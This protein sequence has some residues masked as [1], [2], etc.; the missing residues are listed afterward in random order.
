[1]EN[2]L[3]RYTANGEG[4]WAAGKRLLPPELVDEAW[5]QRKWMPKPQLPE[6]EYRFFLTA[7]GKEQ[8]EKTLLNV[9][10]KYLS[11]ITS[12]EV[13]RSSIGTVVHEDEWQVVVQKEIPQ[14]IK[15]VGFDFSWSE[16]KVWALDV[17]TEEMNIDELIW[18][19]DV[20]FLWENGGVYN[21]T[22]REVIKHPEAHQEEYDRTMNADLVHPIDIM[23]NKGRW[24]ILDGLHRLMKAS[25]LSMKTVRVRKIPRERI[26]EIMT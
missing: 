9:H 20:P 21:L 1:M 2:K 6:G 23:Q 10:K 5:E 12:E 19:F 7:K 22:S 3:Y 18:H 4:I 11:N 17:P 8:Y 16:E 24:L 26:P 25:L 14:I 13:D 15:D